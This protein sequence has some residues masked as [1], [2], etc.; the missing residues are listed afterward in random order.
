VVE[1]TRSVIV[2]ALAQKQRHALLYSDGD[3]QEDAYG[4][5]AVGV[6][7]TGRGPT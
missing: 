2:V 7:V 5:M 3:L 4:G 1:G 6:T